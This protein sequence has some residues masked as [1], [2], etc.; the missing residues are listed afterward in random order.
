MTPPAPEPHPVLVPDPAFRLE[1]GVRERLFPWYDADALERLLSR[2]PPESRAGILE[3]FLVP[4]EPGRQRP[5]L[6]RL[7]HP[8]LQAIL[9]EVWVPFWDGCTEEEMAEQPPEL[10]GRELAMLRRRGSGH[11]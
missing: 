3:S 4:E 6:V 1:A 11:G 7:G 2:T 9:E 10:P 5:L 8:E